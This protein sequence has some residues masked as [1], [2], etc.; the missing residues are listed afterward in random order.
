MNE[1]QLDHN[2]AVAIKA[3]SKGWL[4]GAP[5]AAEQADVSESQKLT[6]EAMQQQQQL[7]QEEGGKAANGNTPWQCGPYPCAG[8]KMLHQ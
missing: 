2:N 4:T 3:N 5:L 6:A 1:A 7:N 8:R